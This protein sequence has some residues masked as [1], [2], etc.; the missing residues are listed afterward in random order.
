LRAV[1][2]DISIPFSASSKT[3]IGKKGT[4]NGIMIVDIE[5]VNGPRIEKD[6]DIATYA[7]ESKI[8]TKA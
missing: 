2:A 8:N 1:Y 7:N 3:S 5:N 6:C 4:E